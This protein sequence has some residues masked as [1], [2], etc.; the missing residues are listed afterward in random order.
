MRCFEKKKKSSANYFFLG[1]SSKLCTLLSYNHSFC[2]VLLWSMSE[3]PTSDPPPAYQN[4]SNSSAVIPAWIS[5]NPEPTFE[6][7]LTLIYPLKCVCT[8]TKKTKN[9][10]PELEN[11]G[12]YEV[13]ID[14]GW[15]GFLKVIAEK[16]TVVPF[17]LVVPSFE[18]HWL[19]PASSPWLPAQDENRFASMLK[20]IKM[21]SEPYVI[22]CMQVPI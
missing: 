3:I 17:T 10:K 5:Q 4:D 12:P 2:F 9:M 21:K 13:L 19:K 6:L 22:I 14:I 1:K 16:L 18:W 20:K 8:S 15:D 7:L 11:K